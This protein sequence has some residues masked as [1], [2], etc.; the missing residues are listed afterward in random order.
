MISYALK[1]SNLLSPNE[2]HKLFFTLFIKTNYFIRS[3]VFDIVKSRGGNV[4]CSL[5]ITTNTDHELF[6]NKFY[7]KCG[8][9]FNTD[10]IE[11]TITGGR[12]LC[13]LNYELLD[14]SDMTFILVEIFQIN[15]D[16]IDILKC[17]EERKEK[18]KIIIN[19]YLN[20]SN[21]YYDSLINEVCIY[22]EYLAREFAKKAKNQ[23]FK[24]FKS[25]VDALMNY[26][27]ET[28]I[29]YNYIGSLLYP[30]YYARNQKLHPYP[31]VEFYKSYAETLFANLSE[32]IIYLTEYEIGF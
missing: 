20:P 5:L 6:N 7:D 10:N 19:H 16:L 22:G 12:I 17:D 30:I 25:A 2:K 8:E 21:V 3:T 1:T 23:I 14:Y 4:G 24:D 31:D 15:D 13:S 29:K 32:I 28:D 11:S 27:E 18:L 26:K 9:Y